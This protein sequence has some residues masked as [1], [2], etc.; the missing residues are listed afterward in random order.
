MQKCYTED[1]QANSI[2]SKRSAW[3]EGTSGSPVV[4]GIWLH[5][6]GGNTFFTGAGIQS[7]RVNTDALVFPSTVNGGLAESE[8]FKDPAITGTQRYMLPNET[9]TMALTGKKDLSR[10]PTAADI[11]NNTSGVWFNSKKGYRTA[12][13]KF[14]GKAAGI[15]RI[16]RKIRETQ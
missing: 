14:A 10:D 12:L 13:C 16:Q 8:F 6:F 4:G 2:I 9:G 15:V 5:T 1:F 7:K 11:P 3:H